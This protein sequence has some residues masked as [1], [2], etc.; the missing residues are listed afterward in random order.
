MHRF[1]RVLRAV[2]RTL[3]PHTEEETLPRRR[4]RWPLAASLPS[5][6]ALAAG[7][8]AFYRAGA[9]AIRFDRDPD[10]TSCAHGVVRAFPHQYSLQWPVDRLHLGELLVRGEGTVCRDFLGRQDE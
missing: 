2:G 9:G 3:R 5:V 8:V 10:H 7:H 6:P 4:S 1:R